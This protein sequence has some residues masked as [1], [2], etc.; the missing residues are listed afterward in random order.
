MLSWVNPLRSLCIFS[1]WAEWC[2]ELK[3]ASFICLAFWQSRLEGW[4]PLALST[5]ML[6]HGLSVMMVSGSSDFVYGY[7]WLP[8]RMKKKKKRNET[9][10]FLR[11]TQERLQVVFR[12]IL[13]SKTVSEDSFKRRGNGHF[14][15]MDGA[16][17]NL[18]PSLMHQK[19]ILKKEAGVFD[20]QRLLFS[21]SG[22]HP[23]SQWCELFTFLY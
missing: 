13:L 21:H 16:S 19:L 18:W 8:E 23:S 14:L 10:S 7:W 22:P 1:L 3:A 6:T 12:H 11:Q 5:G 20:K 2:K 9:C 17:E 4:G 15:F